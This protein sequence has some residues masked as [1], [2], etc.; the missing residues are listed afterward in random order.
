MDIENIIDKWAKLEPKIN[1]LRG[2]IAERKGARDQLLKN[3]QNEEKNQI[4][5]KEDQLLAEQ[6]SL[7]LQSEIVER[8]QKATE[9][10]ES[11]GTSSLRM[12]YGDDYAL[13]FNTFDEK[14]EKGEKG[15]F[16]MEIQIKSDLK[17][18][19]LI[20]GLMADFSNRI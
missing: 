14:R 5:L 6:A 15:G 11:I 3:K 10:I 2:Q 19:P 1:R 16:K 8:R 13:V 9:A 4:S 20:T 17:N 12:I 7:F 18:Q